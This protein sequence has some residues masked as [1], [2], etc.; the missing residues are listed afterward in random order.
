MFDKDLDHRY[1]I[2]RKLGEGGM[3]DVYLAE[4][5]GLGRVEALKILRPR[6]AESPE[7]VSRFR[8]EARA[9]NRLQHPNIVSVYDFGKLPDGRFYLTTE[10][11]NG[12]RLDHLLHRLGRLPAPRAMNL[13]AQLADAIDHAH[14]RGVIHRDLKPE[15]MIIVEHRG[16]PDV[17]KVLDFGIAKIIAPDYQDSIAATAQG[18]IYGTPWYMSPEQIRG[19]GTEPLIDIYALGCIGYHLLTGEAPFE[20]KSME[21]LHAHVTK[22]PTA[23][24]QH[25]PNAQIPSALDALILTCLEKRPADR[26]QTGKEARIAL[27]AVP[28]F[29]TPHT[30]SARRSYRRIPRGVLTA[31]SVEF[32][33]VDADVG[34]SKRRTEHID[35]RAVTIPPPTEDARLTHNDI[36]R[37]LAEALLDLG[38]SDFQ[39]VMSIGNIRDMEAEIDGYDDDVEELTARTTH[40]EQRERQRESSLRFA[41]GELRFDRDQARGSGESIASDVD[42]QISELEKRL[43]EVHGKLEAELEALTDQAIDIVAE[44]ATREEQLDKRYE[45]LAALITEIAP[46]FRSDA[47]IA[48]R[49]AALAQ[50]RKVLRAAS[51]K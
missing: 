22:K 37:S 21:V 32:K 10:Y 26:Y 43:H 49:I 23:P 47:Y 42:F 27:E 50:A 41:I 4:H 34:L 24:S 25:T 48:E 29:P 40:I 46:R 3:G 38:C 1:R 44:Q 12:E 19:E 5:V 51:G 13:M 2:I 39:L 35:T 9:T 28:G 8:R 36:L 20:G 16:T 7:F 30:G 33:D 14:S 6:L 18:D 31:P 45:K 11:A 17:L 15:N